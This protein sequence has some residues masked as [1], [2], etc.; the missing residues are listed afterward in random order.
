[1]EQVKIFSMNIM[2]YDVSKLKLIIEE[3]NPDIILLQE[4]R[5]KKNTRPDVPLGFYYIFSHLAYAGVMTLVKH[6]INDRLIKN[7]K[8]LIEGRLMLIELKD[9][10]KLFNV[11]HKRITN[12]K[13]L[14][15]RIEYDQLFLSEMIKFSKDNL[16]LVGDFNSVYKLHDSVKNLS[17]LEDKA[18]VCPK[19]WIPGKPLDKNFGCYERH[20]MKSFID[21]FNFVDNGINKGFTFKKFNKDCMRIDF[22]LSSTPIESYRIKDMDQISDHKALIFEL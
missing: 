17:I 13:D 1:M 9:G 19:N 5:I 4:I 11:Y 14:L 20:F 18:R 21:Q 10:R 8:T 15:P 2:C 7:I 12:R 22:L 16:I 3:E 6:D